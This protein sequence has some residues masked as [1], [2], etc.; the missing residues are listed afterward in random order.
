MMKHR[1]RCLGIVL[2]VA[3]V[4]VVFA[5]IARAAGSG[6]QA[7][8]PLAGPWYAPHELKALI[9]YSKATLPQKKALLAGTTVTGKA[10]AFAGPRYTPQELKALIAYSKAS[11]AQKQVLLAG[12]SLPPAVSEGGSFHWGDA[13]I[14]AGSTLGSL[15][16]VAGF[17]AWLTRTRRQRRAPQHA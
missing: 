4:M 14:G 12:G 7:T 15:L 16:I 1:V 13:G 6:Q 2:F 8:R 11:F 17:A 5:P 9:A 3:S 10:A